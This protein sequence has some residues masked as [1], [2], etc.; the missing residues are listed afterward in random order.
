MSNNLTTQTN[1]IN[2]HIVDSDAEIALF[3]AKT[4]LLDDEDIEIH[5]E[6]HDLAQVVSS[7]VSR[8]NTLEVKSTTINDLL[9]ADV[10]LQQQI[11][12]MDVEHHEE[13]HDLA[14]VLSN[15]TTRINGLEIFK[16]ESPEHVVLSEDEYD[17]MAEH[18]YDTFYF[19]YEE[20]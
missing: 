18:D 14:D 19:V 11:D 12:D 2:L 20:D 7:N 16:A 8:I 15:H 17:R 3:N 5:E 1:R 4:N 13:L 9:S 10:D 6:I